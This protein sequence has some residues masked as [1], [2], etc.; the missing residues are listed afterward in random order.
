MVIFFFA[1]VPDE[2]ETVVSARDVARAN[3]RGDDANVLG[4]AASEAERGGVS[5]VVE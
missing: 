4:Q 1:L 3:A 5:D 2:H